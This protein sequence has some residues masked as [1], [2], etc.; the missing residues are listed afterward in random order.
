MSDDVQAALNGYLQQALALRFDGE[1]PSLH[2]TPKELLDALLD[3]RHR[4]DR[5]E[6]I[7][8]RAIR[9]RARAHRASAAATAVAD[10]AWDWAVQ[11]ARSAPVTRGGE[12]SSARERHADAN[13]AVLDVR[14]AARAATDLVSSCDEATDV[15]RLA[16][17]GLAD[18]RYELL[19]VLR[20]LQFES[21][22]ER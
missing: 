10:D 22:L 12:Y 8:G 20:T 2:A 14:R 21:H 19:T 9:L 4:L 3:T 18:L 17:R 11:R 1:P 5:A 6:A 16:H 7:L 13:L 15:I